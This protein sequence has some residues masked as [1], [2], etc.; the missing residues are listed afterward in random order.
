ML[1]ATFTSPSLISGNA[2]TCPCSV[3][4]TALTNVSCY[5]GNNGSAIA[6]PLNGTLP[7]TYVWT[8][9]PPVGQGTD[10]ISGLLAGTYTVSLTDA[11]AC[12]ATATCVISQP[13][14][15]NPQIVNIKCRHSSRIKI[16]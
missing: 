2:T 9:N 4:A 14:A 16:F 11:N 15:L 5:G 3:S 8:P 12:V 7:F 1:L 13:S 6:N 10:T